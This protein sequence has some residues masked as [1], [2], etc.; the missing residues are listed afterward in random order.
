M[1]SLYIDLNVLSVDTEQVLVNEQRTGLR[2]LLDAEGFTTIP[3]R[4]RHR[5][6]F[7]GGFHCF[8]LDTHRDGACDDYLS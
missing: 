7:G 5:R 4:H 8:I 6:L 2:R 3:V 1:N